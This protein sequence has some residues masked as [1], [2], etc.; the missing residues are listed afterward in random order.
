[1]KF[2]AGDRVRCIENFLDGAFPGETGTVLERFTPDSCRVVFDE[3]CEKRH[4]H[5]GRCKKGHGWCIFDHMLEPE[6][7]SDLGELPALDIASLL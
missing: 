2:K 6:G 5:D 1:M 3:Y 7:V 4:D